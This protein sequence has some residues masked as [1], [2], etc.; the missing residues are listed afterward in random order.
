MTDVRG[1][2]GLRYDPV[3]APAGDV[4][5]PP[6]DV[7]DASAQAAY[8][9]R[10]PWNV[11]RVE[12]G[13]GPADLNV[14]GNRY[15]AAATALA[16]WR[17]LGILVREASPA[18]YLH[19]QEFEF[20][21]TRLVRRGI[22]V[23]G[24]LHDWSEGVVRPHEYT[25]AGPKADRLALLEATATNT[26]PLW[27]VYP[28]PDGA[29]KEALADSWRH[30]PDIVTEADGEVHRV[31]VVDDPG[32]IEAVRTAFATRA[33]YIADGHHRYETAAR[34]R[35]DRRARAGHV[36]PDAAH[37]FA[38]WL[39]VDVA[40]PGLVVRPYHRVIAATGV[41]V[42]DAVAALA[43]DAGV[44]PIDATAGVEAATSALARHDGATGEH[45]CVLW[46]RGRAWRVVARPG[47]RWHT[48]LPGGHS[49]AW[50]SLDVVVVD[51]MVVRGAFGIEASSEESGASGEVARIRYTPDAAE[52]VRQVEAGEAEVAVL[53]R[54]V[55]VSQVCAVA[56]AG[57]RMPP[58][59]TYFHPKPVTGLV[60]NALD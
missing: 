40:D 54:P 39:L 18:M 56:D 51:S 19:S 52:A 7:I 30:P 31:T 38:L 42:E 50:R 4:T 45:A 1:F 35:D 22:L 24:R 28:D 26:S 17:A 59:S 44:T 55:P 60:M 41:R 58:K 23:A 14:P 15:E 37:E 5:C 36:D 29:V 25:R 48:Q 3:R 20:E 16:S 33:T 47:G 13:S 9:A 27:L 57:D 49:D 6:Y 32:T 10:S 53:V 8:H 46:A 11:V 12:L 34:Y 43:T 21:G 2:R